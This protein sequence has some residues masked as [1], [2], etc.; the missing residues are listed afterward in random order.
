M[1]PF[2]LAAVL[3]AASGC[4]GPQCGT[5]QGFVA[6][7]LIGGDDTPVRVTARPART[8]GVFEGEVSNESYELNVEG[9]FTYTIKAESEGGAM[10]VEHTLLVEACEEYDLDLELIDGG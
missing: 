4:G 5:T 3:V 8:N 9:G 6:G 7:A 1:R 10:S 2:M